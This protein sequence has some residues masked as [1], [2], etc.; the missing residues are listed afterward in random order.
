VGDV[1]SPEDVAKTWL[2][3]GRD[4]P[5]LRERARTL[6]ITRREAKLQVARIGLIFAWAKSDEPIDPHC[7]DQFRRRL[8]T[9]AIYHAGEAISD[10]G[11][12]PDSF[13]VLTAPL[14][15]HACA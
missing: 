8:L 6:G 11:P 2:V 12:A 7:T 4:C 13:P 1:L 5:A 9:R 14:R 15:Q 3:R 10:S